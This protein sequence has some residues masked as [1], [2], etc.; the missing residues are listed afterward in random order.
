MCDNEDC[1]CNDHVNSN[2]N[3]TPGTTTGGDFPIMSE[4]HYS[5]PISN[6]GWECPKCGAVYAG[7]HQGVAVG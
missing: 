7:R 3:I 4:I 2:T 1:G 5:P 6:M